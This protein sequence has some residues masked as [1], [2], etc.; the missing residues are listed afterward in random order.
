VLAGGSVPDVAGAPA[1]TTGAS[2]SGVR[3]V[4][5]ADLVEVKVRYK[6]VDAGTDDPALEVSQSLAPSDVASALDGADLDL[7]W[8]SAVAA[9]SEVLKRSPYA[10]SVDLDALAT[11]FEAQ[12]ELDAERAEFYQLFQAARGLM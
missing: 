9:F 3:E 4:A 7:Q 8:A 6:H 12:S 2:Y 1:P 5:S 11:V 10:S